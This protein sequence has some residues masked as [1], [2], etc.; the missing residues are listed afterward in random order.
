MKRAIALHREDNVAN[1]VESVNAGDIVFYIS[2]KEQHRLT[3]GTDVPFGFKIA[4]RD[5]SKG[6][7][8]IKYAQII[9]RAS[10][11]IRAGEL[12]HIHNVEGSRGRGDCATQ[13]ES[14]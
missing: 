12:V 5:I 13:R 8:I 9:G 1:V 14:T 11:N 10:A 4:M 7:A 6:S 3:A 2:A